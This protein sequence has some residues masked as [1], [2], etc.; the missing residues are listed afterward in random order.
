MINKIDICGV[1]VDDVSAQNAINLIFSL[2]KS[3]KTGNL[4]VTVNSEFIM[5]ARRSEEFL[6]ILKSAQLS[7]ADGAWVVFLK[8]ILGGKFQNRITGSDL[9]EMVCSQ[10]A[11]KTVGIGFLGGFGG[12]AKTVSKRQM[13]AYPGLKVV[14]SEAGNP[15]IGYDK[16]IRRQILRSGRID[17][18]FVAY[19]MGKQE[20][21]IQRNREKLNVGVFIGVGGAF[22]YISGKKR[23]APRFLMESGF[24]WL[25]RLICEPSRMWRMRV[26]PYFF[27]F[28]LFNCFFKKLGI[29]EKK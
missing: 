23:R 16:R 11:K 1:P 25:W 13:K 19:G 12:V 9:I 7:L 18:L 6:K 27:F 15:S 8:R 5:L 20:Y 4:V 26:L 29:L 17:I 22:D 28:S 10:G 2:A 14:F 24:E 3:A 21:W